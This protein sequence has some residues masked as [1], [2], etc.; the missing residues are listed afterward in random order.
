MFEQFIK[1]P[2]HLAFYRSGPYAEERRLFLE[3]IVQEVEARRG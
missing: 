1:R 3:H 2:K